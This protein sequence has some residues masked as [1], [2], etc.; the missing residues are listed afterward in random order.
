MALSTAPL[1]VFERNLSYAR[2]MVNGG[3]A[4]A[5]LGTSELDPA[6]LHRAAWTQSISAFDHWLHL[7][8]Y[9]RTP[10]IVRKVSG[11]RPP[12]LAKTRLPFDMVE[13]VQ[14]HGVELGEAFADHMRTEIGRT[15][16]HQPEAIAEGVRYLVNVPQ[17]KIWDLTA[18]YL[19]T[20]SDPPWTRETAR[21]RHREVLDRR[22][23]IAHEAD[24]DS[25]TGRRRSM[26]WQEAGDA[27][28]WIDDLGHAL[29]RVIT[30]H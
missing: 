11:E 22:N 26:T 13:K 27:V 30:E 7:E 16:F 21:L 4:L 2:G 17:A 14:H 3:R 5:R 18:Q 1:A 6:D 9:R 12:M 10:V 25:T 24:L 8:I 29:Y 19:T 28:A 15:S 20:P 23:R